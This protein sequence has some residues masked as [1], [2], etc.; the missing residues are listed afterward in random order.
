MAIQ[1]LHDLNINYNELQNAKLHVTSATPT[2][3]KGVIYFDDA[4][5]VQ[6]LKFHDGSGWKTLETEGGDDNKFLSSL[7]FDTSDGI[8]TATMS[9]SGTV[10][11]DLD[12]RYSLSTHQ[13]AFSDLTS[14]PTTISG[15]G[16]TDALVLGTSATTALALS[17]I[18][19]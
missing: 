4:V 3:V 11:V 6:K 1:Y 9:D 13:H 17:L 2:A 12:G 19:N 10:T 15:Y 16:I 18:H 7:A 8:I 5:G 14:K